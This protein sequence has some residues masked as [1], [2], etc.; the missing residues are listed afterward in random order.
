MKFPHVSPFS[1][2]RI[3]LKILFSMVVKYYDLHFRRRLLVC[4][5][6]WCTL[7]LTPW[8]L[9]RTFSLLRIFCV[10]RCELLAAMQSF[11]HLQ[12]WHFCT[13]AFVFVLISW[14]LFVRGIYKC[15]TVFNSIQLFWRSFGDNIKYMPIDGLSEGSSKRRRKMLTVKQTE[16]R[17]Y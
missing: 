17:T 7:A 8:S 6:L 12:C 10:R 11:G 15:I 4:H 2:P 9:H 16:F 1:H 5:K 3:S 13:P 14:L